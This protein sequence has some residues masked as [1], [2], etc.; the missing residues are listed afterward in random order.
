MY[1]V[2]I[3]AIDCAETWIIILVTNNPMRICLSLIEENTSRVDMAFAFSTGL[4]SSLIKK[5]VNKL[6]I[7]RI[8]PTSR[9]TCRIPS[10][11]AKTPP[12]SGPIKLP[13]IIPVASVP[14]A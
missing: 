10:H 2:K 7:N 8:K 13:P 12:K 14:S 4:K 6:Q 11:S 9:N 5:T 3:G 1:S